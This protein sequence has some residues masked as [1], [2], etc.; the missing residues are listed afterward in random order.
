MLHFLS[1][2]AIFQT[3]AKVMIVGG[4]EK[5]SK[6]KNGVKR[7]RMKFS[8]NLAKIPQPRKREM[9]SDQCEGFSKAGGRRRKE[10]KSG[11]RNA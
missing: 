3:G 5:K 8:A 6:T 2:P 11:A 7:R 10:E 4:E 1:S 9:S